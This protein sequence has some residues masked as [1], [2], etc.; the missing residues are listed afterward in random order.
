MTRE[1]PWHPSMVVK[2]FMNC[3]QLYP[4]KKWLN[5]VH[6]CGISTNINILVLYSFLHYLIIAPTRYSHDFK[7]AIFQKYLVTII[8]NVLCGIAHRLMP[9]DFIDGKSTLD[10][11]TAW[12]HQVMSH[13]LS[14]YW[15]CS[16][17]PYSITRGQWLL[18]HWNQDKM[19]AILKTTFSNVFYWMIIY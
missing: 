11:I 2:Y 7:Y 1:T 17:I 6:F 16:V 19:A 9:W 4:E 12:C 15:Q 10:Q 5:K 8:Q 14:Q 18:T 3:W 13:Y